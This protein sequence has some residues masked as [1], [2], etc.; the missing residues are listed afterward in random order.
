MAH[1]AGEFCFHPSGFKSDNLFQ[2]VFYEKN[3]TTTEKFTDVRP[4]E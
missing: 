4:S 1:P 3:L 2:V